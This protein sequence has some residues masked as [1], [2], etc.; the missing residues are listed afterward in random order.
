MRKAREKR[1]V[2]DRQPIRDLADGTRSSAEIAALTG[3]SAKFVQEVL[4]HEDLPRLPRNSPHGARNAAY[5]GG[6][7]V[8]R[9]GYVLMAARWHPHCRKTGMIYAHRLVYE[10]ANGVVLSKAQVID[11]IDGLKQN[12]FPSNL[13]IFEKN[14][15]HLKQTLAGQVPRWSM[16]GWKKMNTGHRQRKDQPHIH[17]YRLLKQSGAVREQ[18]TSLARAQ[19]GEAGLDLLRKVFHTEL[20][21]DLEF[22]QKQPDRFLEVWKF[23]TG[24]ELS[25]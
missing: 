11:H 8:D 25:Q 18:Q 3:Y 23:R 1:R 22:L 2:H 14:S 6:G 15:D 13:R 7:T 21:L 20:G 12:N 9:D 4:L 5:R 16:L 19:F 10:L 24:H 17:S